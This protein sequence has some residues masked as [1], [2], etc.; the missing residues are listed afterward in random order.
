[1]K[2]RKKKN[3][4][5]L[6]NGQWSSVKCSG[7]R[8]TV[9]G[10]VFFHNGPAPFEVAPD[11]AFV[12]S[13]RRGLRG[14]QLQTGQV[15][16]VSIFFFLMLGLTL[17]FSIASPALRQSRILREHSQSLSG[18]TA[19]ES[20]EEDVAYRIRRGKHYTATETLSLNGGSATTTVT[21]NAV[22]SHIELRTD[23]SANRSYRHKY[24]E[25]VRGNVVAFN[26]GAQAGG[27]GIKLQNTSS[28]IGNVYSNGGATGTSNNLI[29]GTLV[30]AST[31]GWIEGLHATS[32][33]YAH[34]IK[35]STIDGDAY[36]QTISGSTVG[37]ASHPGSSDKPTAPLPISDATLD[38]WEQDAA[39]G[40]VHSTP[41]PLV[42]TASHNRAPD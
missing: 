39:A 28:I 25:L 20:L 17:V 31:T 23:G 35:S 42:I 14:R 22:T 15:M 7:Q 26:Y 41:C 18:F 40:G 21:N 30:S 2:T 6:V 11:P 27:G 9:N 34:M 5:L 10:Q 16:M 8:S 38:Q 32:S 12:G 19:A 37:G 13:P 29:Y 33:A 24:M 1:M 36:Y 3:P 4:Q